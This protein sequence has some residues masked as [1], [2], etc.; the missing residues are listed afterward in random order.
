M[1]ANGAP[2]VEARDLGATLNHTE[3]V[4]PALLN[5]LA[6]FASLQNVVTD[7][8]DPE[9]ISG[10]KL[11]PNPAR[12]WIQLQGISAGAMIEL[13]NGQGQLLRQARSQ[14]DHFTLD[15]PELRPGAYWVRVVD[16]KQLWTKALI[17]N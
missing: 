5:G 10:I 17:I 3:C 7:L 6:F 13:Y 9:G 16:G 14:G 4:A 11:Y 15:I 2:D 12:D 8:D 1:N